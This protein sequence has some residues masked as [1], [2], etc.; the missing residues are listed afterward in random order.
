M[1]DED[2][3]REESHSSYISMREV[4]PS[5]VDETPAEYH[6]ESYFPDKDNSTSSPG[7]STTLGLGNHGPAYYRICSS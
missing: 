2:L 7:S 3:Q 5:P 6:E 4:E 1:A